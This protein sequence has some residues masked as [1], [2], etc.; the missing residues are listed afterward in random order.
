MIVAQSTCAPPVSSVVDVARWARPPVPARWTELGAVTF[1]GRRQELAVLD[2][3][4]SAVLAGTPHLVFVGGEPGVGKSRLVLEA[5]K[6]LHRNDAAVLLG[7]CAAELGEPYQPFVEPVQALRESLSAGSLP[8]AADTT[9]HERPLTHW[10]EVLAGLARDGA[11][12][13][14]GHEYQRQVCQAVV[15][16]VSAASDVYPLVLVL[17]D[18]HWSG[19]AGLQL[20]T[21]LGEH[22]QGS[23]LLVLATYR[24]TAPDRSPALVHA[25]ARLQR[26]DRVR[27][28]DLAPL[29]LQDLT[30][31]LAQE[32]RLP[33][34]RIR[35]AASALLEQTG[36]NPFLLRE[37]WRD[38]FARGGPAAL[39]SPIPAPAP[40]RDTFQSR[41][42]RLSGPA[43]RIVDLAAIIG[44]EFEATT[45]IAASESA[46]ELVLVAL[47]EVMREGLVE[48][49][50]AADGRFRFPHALARTAVLEL[51]PPSIRTNDH[52]RVAAVLEGQP[53]VDGRIQR[54]AH[55]YASAHALGYA[56]KA[57][58]YLV[59]AARLADAGLAHLDAGRLFERAAGITD[60]AQQRDSLRLR[61]ARSYL[62][63]ADFRRARD[64]AEQVAV[65]GVRLNRLE[66][67]IEYECAS[68]R[69]G[70][71]GHRA[72]DLLRSALN[73]TPENPAQAGYVRAVACLGRAL[74]FTGA[75]DESL[76]VGSRAI[77]F[78]RDL[79]DDELLAD[80]LQASL[81]NTARPD[82][83]AVNLRRATE[84]S[85]LAERTGD[86]GQ[87]GP[88]AYHR[89][90]I[91]YIRGAPAD[92]DAA[93]ADLL[94][95]SR[96]TGQDYFG[97][98]ARCITYAQQ[99]T[100]GQFVEAELTCTALRELGRSVGENDIEGPFG[101]QTYMIRRETRALADVRRLI[102]GAERPSDHWAPGLLALYTELGLDRPAAR[103]LRWILDRQLPQDQDS[104]QWP[105]VLAFL[106]EAALALGD[107][108]T[109]ARLR[110]ALAR[111]A[112]CN[113]LA[114]SF[115]ALFGSAD[116]YL[117]AVDSLLGR[118]DPEDR[119]AAALDMDTRMRAPL[120]EAHTLAAQ[121]VHR[122]RVGAGAPR[123][124]EA[125]ERARSIA[126]P[127]ALNRVLEMLGPG[128]APVRSDAARADS[129]TKREVEVLRLLARGLNNRQIGAQLFITENTAA[130]HVRSILA[131]TGSVNRT[132][133]ALYANEHGL[134][135]SDG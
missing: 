104:A 122:R 117:G 56:D 39:A 125:L 75:T 79:G 66:A 28:L 133:A 88:A 2:D 41:L 17:E 11:A 60:D 83:M 63:G 95:A 7:T 126:V 26:L 33:S 9:L 14:P 118:G 5:A 90:A 120:H 59:E 132:R 27:R 30:D 84:L 103:V 55:H 16:V 96:A 74:A 43:R 24:S 134:S 121:V 135:D 70:L 94:R 54:I 36:G 52:A 47:D 77:L 45:V 78:A 76:A 38:L 112:G 49:A 51:S 72:V 106:V 71:P 57:V 19:S 40:V 42:D 123:V 53:A 131:K 89:G 80:A 129:L 124:A 68:W 109:A 111:Y 25:L 73:D 37:L 4:W 8:L 114:G 1:V 18:L 65:A 101:V 98:T 48:I 34:H 32:T 100:T 119:F 35:T 128:A 62:L 22:A 105:M 82:F 113:L 116:R 61:A 110:P 97:Y 13:A 108:P 12:G 130:N 21:Y 46:A 115:V 44:E 3:V 31:F 15:A 29:S 69:T 20:L 107:A 81:W 127:L 23:R 67:A 102:T 10:L 64:L 85:T 86:L 99:F 50:T 58:Q 6:V 87:L 92:L 93:Q 91:A